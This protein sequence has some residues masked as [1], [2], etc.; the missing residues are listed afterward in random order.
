[1]AAEAEAAREA[2]AKVGGGGG[3]DTEILHLQIQQNF[4]LRYFGPRVLACATRGGGRSEAG[5]C[6]H[7]LSPPSTVHPLRGNS[8][9]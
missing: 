3:V 7:L 9:D 6:F 5:H 4:S 1:M 8:R 2:R